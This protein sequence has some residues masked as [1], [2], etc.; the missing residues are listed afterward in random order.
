MEG[1]ASLR[2]SKVDEVSAFDTR[3]Y[4]K[5]ALRNGIRAILVQ[6]STSKQSAAAVS[7]HCGAANDPST[8]QGFHLFVRSIS[9]FGAQ[10]LTHSHFHSKV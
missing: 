10:Y 8:Y 1:F 7:V 4:E 3:K 5:L 9:Q 6:D 2:S